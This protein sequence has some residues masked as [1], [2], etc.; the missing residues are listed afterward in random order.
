M[1]INWRLPPKRWQLTPKQ[2]TPKQLTPKQLTPKQLTPKQL[3]PKQLWRPEILGLLAFALAALSTYLQFQEIGGLLESTERS[4]RLTETVEHMFNQMRFAEGGR[5]GYLLT[6]HPQYIELYSKS[7][8]QTLTDLGDLEAQV[9]DRPNWQAALQQ[10][11]PQVQQRLILTDRS[12]ELLSVSPLRPA[13]VALVPKE[14]VDLTLQGQHLQRQIQQAIEQLHR[15]E[16]ETLARDKIRIRR[17]IGLLGWL[18]AL[19][20][21]LGFGGMLWGRRLARQRLQLRAELAQ[22][23]LKLRNVTLTQS[24]QAL[25]HFA[26]IAAHD[27]QAPLR[28]IVQH[29]ALLE[30]ELISQLSVEQS[31]SLSYMQ[32]GAQSLQTLVSAILTYSR[33][34]AQPLN[35]QRVDCAALVVM[36]RE[37]MAIAPDQIILDPLPVVW[38]DPVL[39]EQLLQNLIGNALKFRGQDC[40]PIRLGLC[41][42]PYSQTWLLPPTP[43][44]SQGPLPVEALTWISVWGAGV[45]IDLKHYAEV[46]QPFRRLHPASQYRGSGLGLSI[47]RKIVELHRGRIGLNSQR[48]QGCT[49]LI[50]LPTIPSDQNHPIG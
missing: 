10:I 40:T 23:E 45:G 1:A 15:Q 21:G 29:G 16:H 25:E 5:R 37:R 19:M 31:Q 32:Q 26:A 20:V 42:I 6:G 48:H 30:D 39:L 18:T 41:G 7:R 22:T 49:V 24:N 14:Q 3:T 46:F 44:L 13:S 4:H 36:L 38:G 2:L 28:N 35:W 33:L 17:E 34:D 8:Q 12:M 50:G 11:Q 27:I 9:R 43:D 47:C